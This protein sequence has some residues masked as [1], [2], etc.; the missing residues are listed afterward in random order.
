MC[1]IVFALNL[2]IQSLTFDQ[3][4]CANIF[5]NGYMVLISLLFPAVCETCTVVQIGGKFKMFFSYW[6][7]NLTFIYFSKRGE[8][9]IGE[10]HL[11]EGI[12]YICIN[13]TFLVLVFF[14]TIIIHILSPK[15][16]TI[17]RTIRVALG[18]QA[19][20]IYRSHKCLQE[21]HTILSKGF[22]C[23]GGYTSLHVP[24]FLSFTYQTYCR[25]VH[26]FP[27]PCVKLLAAV[28]VTSGTNGPHQGEAEPRIYQ[29]SDT[30]KALLWDWLIS[31]KM[32]NKYCIF[33]PP[34]CNSKLDYK[35]INYSP[36][37]YI[38]VF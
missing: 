18:H 30:N 9:V 8:A 33:N 15:L 26:G 37:S 38:A 14:H 13:W 11:L 19:L 6:L 29:F 5:N 21:Y 25:L 32:T 27:H 31:L 12:R 22:T 3:N 35:F 20:I 4:F 17:D 2:V 7:M 24:V 28:V 10:G 34:G 36:Y 16:A 23:W 1:S